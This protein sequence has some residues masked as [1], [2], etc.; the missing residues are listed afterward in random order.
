MKNIDVI[1]SKVLAMVNDGI[2]ICEA[3]ESLKFDRV[4]FYQSMTEQQR[5]ELKMAKTLNTW[6]GVGY[7]MRPT[8]RKNK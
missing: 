8:K 4:V 2:N 6:Y 1:Y 5:L 3:L 7:N